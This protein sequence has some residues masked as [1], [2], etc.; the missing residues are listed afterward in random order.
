MI[1]Q[2]STY[3]TSLDALPVGETGEVTHISVLSEAS[4]GITRRLSELGF[5]PGATVECVG[6]SPLGGMRAY[7]V[8]GAVIALRDR[9]ASAVTL[10]LRNEE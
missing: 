1:H 7:R 9:D 6:K 8:S 10:K 2:K 5:T 3:C 4:D